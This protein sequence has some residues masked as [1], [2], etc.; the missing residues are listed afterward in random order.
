MST[1]R[2]NQRRTGTGAHD[3]NQSQRLESS[4]R[5]LVVRDY[6]VAA[7]AAAVQREEKRQEFEAQHG[8]CRVLMRDGKPV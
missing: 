8:P 3:K 7:F 2:G 4:A 6:E 5:K 1:K